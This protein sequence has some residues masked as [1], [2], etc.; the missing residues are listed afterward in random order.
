MAES[1][2]NT[3]LDEPSPWV[4]RFAS[5]AQGSAEVLDLACGSGRHSKLFLDLGG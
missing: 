1:A 5:M 4:L 3:P 2:H